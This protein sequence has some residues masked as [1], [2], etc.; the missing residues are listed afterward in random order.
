MLTRGVLPTLCVLW[1]FAFSLCRY[2]GTHRTYRR[3]RPKKWFS[4]RRTAAGPGEN[5][6]KQHG[7]ANSPGIS[8]RPQSPA[9]RETEYSVEMTELKLF[10]RRPAVAIAGLR[11]FCGPGA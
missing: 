9:L 8:T 3:G 10:L 11:D 6:L 5:F 2:D 7:G 4:R 1:F